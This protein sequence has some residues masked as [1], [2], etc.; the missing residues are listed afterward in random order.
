MAKWQDRNVG[1][2]ERGVTTPDMV[3]KGAHEHLVRRWPCPEAWKLRR[4]PGNG[5]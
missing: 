4:P 5:S 1:K 2:Y 3:G